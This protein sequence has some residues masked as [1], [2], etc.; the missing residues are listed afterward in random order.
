MAAE[1][2]GV[3]ANECGTEIGELN[4]KVKVKAIELSHAGL[5]LAMYVRNITFYRTAR[6]QILMLPL[7]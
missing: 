6:D 2:D 5:Q 7:P 4:V 3:I 1:F